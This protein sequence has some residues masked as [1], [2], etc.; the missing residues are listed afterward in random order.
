MVEKLLIE[1]RR[2]IRSTRK[3][4]SGETSRIA[5]TF[6]LVVACADLHLTV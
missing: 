3:N 2:M 5:L 6:C 4:A 1:K